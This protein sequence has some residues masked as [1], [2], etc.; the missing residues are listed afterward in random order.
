[1]A[2]SLARKSAKESRA[3]REGYL[4]SPA[5]QKF[6]RL[7]FEAIKKS[8]RVAVCQVCG[9]TKREDNPLDLH[10]MSY[11]NVHQG[12]DGRWVSNERPEDVVLLCRKHHK[13]V[14][15]ILDDYRRDY[16]G[17]SRRR[18]S[19]RIIHHLRNHHRQGRR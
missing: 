2:Y 7:Y 17:W 19:T 14:H 12:P 16:R 15:K 4:R 18:A 1:M 13:D 3:Y 8:Q 11:D 10:H 9:R 6:R 5:W